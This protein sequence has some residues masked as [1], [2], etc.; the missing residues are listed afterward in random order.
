MY[1]LTEEDMKKVFIHS[2]LIIIFSAVFF[3]CTNNSSN[4]GKRV[5]IGI[6]SDVTS[7]NP[8]FA[9][10]ITEGNISELIYLG[11]IEH[12]WDE[13]GGDLTSS[14]ML[15]KTWEWSDDS[16]SI[17]IK[18]RDDILW[19]DSIQFTAEDV[20]FTFD[21]YSDAKVQSKFYGLFNNFYTKD[22]LSIDIDKSFKILSPFEIKMSFNKNA[23]P[24]LFDV[25]Y[26][27]L[28][29]HI[30]GKI[31]REELD[32]A[33]E[34]LNPV[35]T[36][37]YKLSSWEKN[38]TIKFTGYDKSI[39][40]NKSNVSELI[41]KIIPDYNARITQLKNGEIDFVEGIKPVD[42]EDLQQQKNIKI[43][44]QKGRSYDYVGWNNLD[45]ES[46]NNNKKIKPNKLFGN[47]N[48]RKALTY[49]INRKVILQ[50]F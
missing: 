46:Y 18:L 45:P 36:G 43:E 44:L 50:E 23:A 12:K 41:F 40:F 38:Q 13:K 39:L 17:V 16:L 25:S 4:Q 35:G 28:P 6:D 37:P 9:F 20:V 27:I 33:E 22:D 26:P 11:L 24:T 15:A 47:S 29:K 14:P 8:M 31:P 3:S 49:A 32:N 42:V 34:N 19:A 2:T 10:N 48:I 5:V 21:V 7:F 1:L 30:F